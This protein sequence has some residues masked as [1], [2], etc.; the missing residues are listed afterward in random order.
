LPQS[1]FALSA[2]VNFSTQGI[3][4]IFHFTSLI[5]SIEKELLEAI[6]ASGWN[7]WLRHHHPVVDSQPLVAYFTSSAW[8]ASSYLSSS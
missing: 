7:V 1:L 6:D 8:L 5:V 3:L 4:D 2:I